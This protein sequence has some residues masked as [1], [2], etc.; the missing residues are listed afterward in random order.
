M[1]EPAYMKERI[2][3]G[4]AGNRESLS[5]LYGEAAAWLKTGKPM[6]QTLADWLAA[7]L[8]ELSEAVYQ[9]REA[10]DITP[11]ATRVIQQRVAQAMKVQRKGAKGRLPSQK[12][13]RLEKALAGD[14][15]HYHDRGMTVEAAIGRAALDREKAKKSVT[16]SEV[17]AAW[18]RFAKDFKK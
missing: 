11:T 12:S 17:K 13:A 15:L 1:S 10:K 6:P 5:R 8:I 18:D 2:E 7:N 4:N 16:E 14:V 3:Q 9:S